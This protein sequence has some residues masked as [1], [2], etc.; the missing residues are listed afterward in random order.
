MV[1]ARFCQ[2]NT[3]ESDACQILRS[4]LNLPQVNSASDTR[5]AQNNLNGNNNNNGR[6]ML[7]Q[8]NEAEQFHCSNCYTDNCNGAS[9]TK[10]GLVLKAMTLMIIM[11]VPVKQIFSRLW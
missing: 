6:R 9:S 1:T 10:S 4:K 3:G 2:L 7:Q 5:L 11:M 8:Q